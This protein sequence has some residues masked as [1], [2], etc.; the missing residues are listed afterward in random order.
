MKEDA[1]KKIELPL[2]AENQ[3]PEVQIKKDFA[4]ISQVNERLNQISGRIEALSGKIDKRR[5]A[6]S[7]QE[8]IALLE[9]GL[10]QGIS[11][12][13]REMIQGRDDEVNDQNEKAKE[14]ALL[15]QAEAKKL[16]WLLKKVNGMMKDF[17][18]LSEEDAVYYATEEVEN[19]VTHKP[20]AIK[21][22]GAEI[23]KRQLEMQETLEGK[24]EEVSFKSERGQELNKGLK[25]VTELFN[26]LG[27][28]WKLDGAINISLREIA[29]GKEE[30]FRSHRDVDVHVIGDV[31]GEQ[32]SA[33]LKEMKSGDAPNGYGAFTK[34][35]RMNQADIVKR[36][37]TALATEFNSGPA[38]KQGLTFFKLNQDGN[39]EFTVGELVI[40]I[41]FS[42]DALKSITGRALPN[43][44]QK[45]GETVDLEGA[46]IH[47]DHIGS[48]LYYKLITGRGRDMID[49][50]FMVEKGQIKPEDVRGVKEVIKA[51]LEAENLHS[52]QKALLDKAWQK[53]KEVERE[54]EKTR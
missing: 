19:G 43:E 9:E 18:D 14:E 34:D 29:K 45:G 12:E 25:V 54:I 30:Y 40:D 21:G 28:N 47:L 51:D 35:E 37:G 32:L 13:S 49:V 10:G 39:P 15:L 52:D 41:H 50:D 20:V 31:N 53:V 46:P 16:E 33:L 17:P 2:K 3:E 8:E 22:G 23:K 27:V 7:A 5:D 36:R 38:P 24:T 26:K 11:S 1:L 48:T 42:K 6:S 4:S 44:W